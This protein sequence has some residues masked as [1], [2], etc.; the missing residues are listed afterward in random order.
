MTEPTNTQRAEA[1]RHLV[2]RISAIRTDRD[3]STD[4][5]LSDLSI[6]TVKAER[7]DAEWLIY[8]GAQPSDGA[9]VLHIL[10]SGSGGSWR[11]AMDDALAD[12]ADRLL[13]AVKIRDDWAEEE[14][15]VA[16]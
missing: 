4:L 11:A 12:Y 1:L 7:R 3:V 14:G 8:L 2:L 10:S 15:E 16:Q 9:D 5:M 13:R 6:R